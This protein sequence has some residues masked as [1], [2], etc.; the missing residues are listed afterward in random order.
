MYN[1]VT[2]HVTVRASLIICKFFYIFSQGPDIMV[3]KVIEQKINLL[4][5]SAKI[6]KTSKKL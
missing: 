3:E 4:D 6:L 2:V 5:I 1:V